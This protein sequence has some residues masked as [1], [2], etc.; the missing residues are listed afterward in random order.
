LLLVATS[1]SEFTVVVEEIVPK[2]LKAELLKFQD[3]E[4]EDELDDDEAAVVA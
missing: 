1:P 2:F 3:V 4:L